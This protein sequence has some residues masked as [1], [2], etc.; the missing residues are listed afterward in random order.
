[1][2]AWLNERPWLV[3]LVVFTL[4]VIPG[5]MRLE[6]VNGKTVHQAEQNSAL[7][8]CLTEYAVDLTDALQDRDAVAVVARGAQVKLWKTFRRLI[9]NPPA[10]GPPVARHQFLGA[11]AAYLRT[12]RAIGATASLN[13]YPD[14]AGCL[15]SKG[16]EQEALGDLLLVTSNQTSWCLGKRV[17]IYG[18]D[19]SE[20]IQGT[21]HADVIRT[22]GGTDLI[23]SGGGRDRVC[24]G[25]GF[26]IVNA[27]RAFDIVKCGPGYDIAQ[28]AEHRIGCEN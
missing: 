12:L 26:D 14:L 13:P 28:D 24:A 21:D 22:Y 1:M 17:T 25:T 20:L 5:F 7:I 19:H 6:Y 10:G 15:K 11:L 27:G 23:V 2:K 8:D 18:T 4:V 9:V 3:S 16:L